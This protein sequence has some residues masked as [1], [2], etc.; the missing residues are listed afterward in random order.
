[1]VVRKTIVDVW[2]GV[3]CTWRVVCDERGRGT[4]SCWGWS[5]GDAEVAAVAVG[6]DGDCGRDGASEDADMM[7]G[8]PDVRYHML[9][10]VNHS[11]EAPL[12][13]FCKGMS[14][15]ALGPQPYALN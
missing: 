13:G 11:K 10:T 7:R 14:S 4:D 3:I 15:T 1:M 12:F 6:S 2:R 9:D 8:M 5:V